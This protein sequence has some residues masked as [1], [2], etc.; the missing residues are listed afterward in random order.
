MREIR[1]TKKYQRLENRRSEK[2]QN[3]AQLSCLFSE[4]P[5]QKGKGHQEQYYETNNHQNNC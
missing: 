1:H 2:D 4:Q 5:S 3:I